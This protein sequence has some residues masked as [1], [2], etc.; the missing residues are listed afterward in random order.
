MAAPNTIASVKLVCES[1]DKMVTV[2]F[3]GTPAKI[4]ATGNFQLSA[5]RPSEIHAE[6]QSLAVHSKWLRRRALQVL[7]TA[8]TQEKQTA[9]EQTRQRESQSARLRGGYRTC[10]DV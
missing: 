7:H 5:T 9:Q 10:C 3:D 4:V 1:A 6:Q 2:R 8:R